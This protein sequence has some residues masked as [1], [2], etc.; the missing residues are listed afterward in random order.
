MGDNRGWGAPQTALWE[1]SG[2]GALGHMPKN[3]QLIIVGCNSLFYFIDYN[4]I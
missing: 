2:I 1:W 4:V 3:Y